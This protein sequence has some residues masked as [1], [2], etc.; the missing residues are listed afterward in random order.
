MET[1]KKIS[2]SKNESDGK[3][4]FSSTNQLSLEGQSNELKQLWNVQSGRIDFIKFP[5]GSELF[6]EQMTETYLEN[7]LNYRT[8]RSKFTGKEE[9]YL[10]V[11]YYNEKTD[12]F[13]KGLLRIESKRLRAVIKENIN[14]YPNSKPEIIGIWKHG[15][16]FNT[17][18]EYF[19]PLEKH[20]MDK[21][22]SDSDSE[23]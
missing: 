2:Q 21:D 11:N 13:E 20:P 8:F 9:N 10:I 12:S 3:D 17:Q 5:S 7:P 14:K 15:T 18:Y 23:K 22:N 19:N 6:I 16:G 1:S 4:L